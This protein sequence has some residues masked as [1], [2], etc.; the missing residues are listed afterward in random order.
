MARVRVQM[1]AEAKDHS[2]VARAPLRRV[3]LQPVPTLYLKMLDHAI[4]D[5]KRTRCGMPT[6]AAILARWWIEEHRAAE[7]DRVDWERSFACACHWLS[8]DVHGW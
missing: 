4:T 7:T 5:A 8:R 3:R 1:T 2:L 6:D